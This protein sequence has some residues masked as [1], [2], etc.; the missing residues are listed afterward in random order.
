MCLREGWRL[1]GEQQG[2]EEWNGCTSV[3]A[4]CGAPPS[5]M[6]LPA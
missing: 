4:S 5:A 3:V 6:L 1:A 2:D